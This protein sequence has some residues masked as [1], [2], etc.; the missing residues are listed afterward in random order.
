MMHSETAYY[1]GG[2][3]GQDADPLPMLTSELPRLS[4]C[5]ASN[6]DLI[7]WPLHPRIF[8]WNQVRTANS[9]TTCSK[10]STIIQRSL[11]T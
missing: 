7:T 8:R 6:D 11:V 5:V 1:T 9:C 10:Q 4:R 3:V 2:A